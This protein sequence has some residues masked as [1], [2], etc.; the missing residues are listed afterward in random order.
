MGGSGHWQQSVGVL[1]P[2][3]TTPLLLES[4]TKPV[5]TSSQVYMQAS[6]PDDA[7]P[8]DLTLE[9]IS[10]PI[11]TLGLGTGTLPVD[12]VQ[13]QEEVGKALGCLLMTRSSFDDHQQKQVLD[14]E[15]ALCQMSQKPPRPSK[16]PRLSV[17][18]PL[19]KLRLTARH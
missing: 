17:P 16:K 13:L 2:Q 14:F 15:M 4:T 18:V 10:L 9:E 7:E 12:V 5:D 3:E 6:I 19:G 1:H 8:E 11:K